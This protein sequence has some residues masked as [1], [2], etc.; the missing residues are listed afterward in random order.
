MCGVG[1][2]CVL[3]R[4]MLGWQVARLTSQVQ[5]PTYRDL[6]PSVRLNLANQRRWT[7]AVDNIIYN[8]FEE[9]VVLRILRKE[10]LYY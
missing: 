9:G 3:S 5:V 1:R 6:P 4:W 10:I 2:V 7:P 8:T